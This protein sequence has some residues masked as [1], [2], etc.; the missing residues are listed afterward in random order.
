MFKK[1]STM[2]IVLALATASAVLTGCSTTE[3]GGASGSP[4]IA[5]L[6]PETITARYE[7]ADRP[8]FE[9]EVAALCPECVV[10]FYNADGSAADQQSQIEAAVTQGASVLVVNAVDTAAVTTAL[11]RA[12]AQGV[13]VIAYMRQIDQ[14]PLAAFI[15][16][17]TF[18]I[19]RQQGEA[20]IEGLTAAGIDNPRIVMINGDAAEPNMG[21]IRDGALDV[22]ASAGA[23][24]V[25][26]FDTPGWDPAAAQ[27]EIDQAITSLGA[28]GFDAVYVMNDGMA[29]GVIA[30]LRSAGIDPSTRFVTGLDADAAALQRVLTGDQYMTVAQPIVE[31]AQATAAIAVA[32]ARGEEIPAEL[33]NEDVDNGSGSAIPTVRTPLTTVTAAT[34]GD[35]IAV[36]LVS[37]ADVCTG[38]YLAA[39]QAAGI[40][41]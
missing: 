29:T 12:Q 5:F 33:F 21:P 10:N 9:K 23:E 26:S 11:E 41:P 39:C 22:F 19:G 14:I 7:A 15:A 16:A 4:T 36:G 34:V 38:S 1:K 13:E 30:A 35:V 20:M 28:D 18:D 2:A 25:A 40:E 37:Y 17:D 8:Q 24:V 6:S 3:E 32:L 27:T 31:Y